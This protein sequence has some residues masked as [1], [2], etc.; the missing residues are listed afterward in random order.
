MTRGQIGQ[1]MIDLLPRSAV[2]DAGRVMTKTELVMLEK[3]FVKEGTI[4]RSVSRLARSGV[5]DASPVVGSAEWQSVPV[6]ERVG[7]GV[8]SLA[9]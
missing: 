2:G 6:A 4:Q 8:L 7:R 1:K 9:V 5:C 3:W